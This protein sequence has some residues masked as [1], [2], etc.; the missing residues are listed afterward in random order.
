GPG[1]HR[2]CA[3]FLATR[4]RTGERG[5]AERLG[6]HLLQAGD[7]EAA[8]TPLL[9]GA[10]ELRERS[11]YREALALLAQRDE[12]LDALGAAVNDARRGEGWVLRARIHLHQGSLGEVFGWA[13]RAEAAAAGRGWTATRA[14]AVRL[15][16]DAARR[17]G[18]LD[19]AAELYERCVDSGGLGVVTNGAAASLWGLGD[20]ARQRGDLPRARDL[21]ARSRR[22]FDELGDQHGVADHLIGL[23]DVARHTGD[24]AA[25][26]DLYLEAEVRFEELGNQYGVSRGLNG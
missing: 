4:A 23:G 9:Y 25:A 6:R 18:D 16:G 17:R 10:R 26:R 20:L 15:L 7:L 11:D 13:E 5:V 24:L 2:A 3:A 21:F 12:I 19:R 8:L 14:E 22:L 1:H